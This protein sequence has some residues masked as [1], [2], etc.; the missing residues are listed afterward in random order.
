M[1]T[2]TSKKYL[3]KIIIGIFKMHAHNRCFGNLDWALK[4]VSQKIGL[5][6]DLSKNI[7]RKNKNYQIH[8]PIYM[9]IS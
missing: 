9:S 4:V 1:H 5:L 3:Q 8:V 6:R 7:K 2:K